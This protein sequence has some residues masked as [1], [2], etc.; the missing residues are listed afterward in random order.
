MHRGETGGTRPFV[1]CLE[2]GR[3]SS[4]AVDVKG[5][6]VRQGGLC[7]SA[8][9]AKEHRVRL[10]HETCDD[11]GWDEFMC[12]SVKT[13]SVWE[14]LTAQRQMLHVLQTPFSSSQQNFGQMKHERRI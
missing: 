4:W 12:L 1:C 8:G 10:V 14:V 5:H 9:D 6:I 3:L 2:T 11:L 13:K 7:S